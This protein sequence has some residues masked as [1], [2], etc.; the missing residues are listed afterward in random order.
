MNILGYVL[1]IHIKRNETVLFYKCRD[2]RGNN[3][4]CDCK[5]KWLVEWMHQTN[6]TLDQ[7]Y[8]SGPPTHQGRKINDLLPHSFDC[9][10]A[11]NLFL[12]LSLV[13]TTAPYSHLLSYLYY[14]FLFSE[15]ASYQSLKFESL[16]VEAFTF[17]I[18]Q[19]VVFAQPFA[20]TCS[21]LEWDH[22]EMTFR[23]FDTIE[24]KY[25]SLKP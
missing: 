7:I 5:L 22:V 19:F 24:S 20:G 25:I 13:L 3:L 6:A 23:T 17:G 14:L 9:I 8:C 2:L 4:I 18:D 11:G 15:F 10:T 21:F 12:S 16:S 1:Q